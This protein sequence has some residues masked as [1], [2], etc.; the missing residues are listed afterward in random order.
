MEWVVDAS[1]VH[2]SLRGIVVLSPTEMWAC[3]VGGVMLN[4]NGDV[5]V[6][7]PVPVSSDIDLFA[8]AALARDQ[9]WA[10]GDQGTIL[11]FDGNSWTAQHLDTHDSLRGV[12]WYPGDD[13]MGYPL[14]GLAVGDNGAIYVSHDP[15]GGGWAAVQHSLTNLTLHSV[16]APRHTDAWAV[17]EH[18]TLLHFDGEVWAWVHSGTDT[19]LYVVEAY[20][21]SAIL[22]AGAGGTIL[23]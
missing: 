3:G 2:S 22:A 1:P 14:L 11:F 19:D 7:W 8:L 12:S 18:G 21:A 9:V 23:W 4:G 15:T 5:W 20:R 10:V 17:G 6:E 13:Y 16:T